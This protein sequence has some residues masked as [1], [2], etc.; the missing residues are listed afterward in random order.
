MQVVPLFEPTLPGHQN[1]IVGFT[2]HI[3]IYPI[4]ING[5]NSVQLIFTNVIYILPCI[6]ILSYYILRNWSLSHEIF[7]YH[8]TKK[9]K[10]TCAVEGNSMAH[11]NVLV[12]R[13]HV[14]LVAK[15]NNIGNFY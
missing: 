1:D 6:N 13:A 2:Y 8:E 9:G 7:P 15:Q 5:I 10:R 12:V 11:L 4:V 14:S 3:Y